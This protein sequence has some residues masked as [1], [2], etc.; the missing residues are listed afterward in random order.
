LVVEPNGEIR[1]NANATGG[2]GGTGSLGSQGGTGGTGSLGSQGGTGGTGSLGSQGGT[3]GTGSLGSQGGT[4]GTGSLGS[5]G[6]T[7][8]TGSRGSQGGTGGTG[9]LGSQGGTGGTGSLGSQGGTGGTGSLGSQGGTGGTGSLGS[10]GGTG[11]TG[12]LGSQGG[13]GGTGSLGSQGGTGGTGSLGSQG[14]TGGTGSLGSQGGT[15]GTGSRGSQGGTGGTGSLG[16]QGG[17]GGT[18]SLGSQGGTGGTG[19][20]GSQGGTGGTGSLGSQGSSASLSGT[21]GYISKFNSS[22]TLVNSIIYENANTIG[23]GA[24]GSTYKLDV[25]GT[26]RF[27]GDVRLD[28][29]ILLNYN[30]YKTASIYIKGVGGN[31]Q[32]GI[33]GS[34]AVVVNGNALSVGTSRG[35]TLTI[36]KKIDFSH[37]GSTTYDTYGLTG[38]S[39]NL[40]VALNNM[41]SAQIGILTSSDAFDASF[42]ANLRTVARKLGLSKLAQNGGSFRRPYAAIFMTSNT[43]DA[44]SSGT[45][46]TSGATGGARYCIEDFEFTSGNSSQAVIHVMAMTDGTGQ[47]AGFSGNQITTALYSTG[48]TTDPVVLVDSSGNVGI[49]NFSPRALLDLAKANNVGQVLLIGETAT[50]T[51]TGFGLDSST[52]GMRIFCPNIASE[53]IY[54]GGISTSDGSTWTRNHSFGIAGK[55]SWLNEQGGNAGIGTT[56]PAYKLDVNGTSGFRDTMAFGPSIG[57]ISWGSMGGGTGFGIRGE[58]GRGLSLGANGTWDYLV[59]NTSGNISINTTSPFTTGGTAQLTLLNSSV[60]LSMGASNSDMSYIRRLSAGVFQW[61]TYN[62]A[63]TGEIHLEPYG[64]NVGIGTTTISAKLHINSTTSGATLV[65]ADGTNGT[66]FSVVDDLSD[67]LM[68]VNNSAGLPV[69]EVFADDR[70]VLGQYGSGDFVLKNNKVGIGQSNPL[71]TLDVSGNIRFTGIPVG[72]STNCLV[73]EPNGE[74][75]RNANATGG[76]GG[77]GSLGSQ[78]GTGGTGSLGSQGGTGGT[79]SRGSQGGTGGTGSL[80]SQGGTG[81]TGS[82][83]SQGGT[84]GTGSL[85]SQGGTGGTGSRGSQGGTGGTGSLGSQGGTGGTGSLGSQGGTGGTG[86]LGSQGSQGAANASGTTNRIAKFTNTTTLGNSLATDDGTSQITLNGGAGAAYYI[87]NRTS[88]SYQGG[89]QWA[90]GGTP[91]WYNYMQSGETGDVLKWFAG[92]SDKLF[93]A[94]GANILGVGVSPSYTLDVNGNA[95]ATSFPTSSD[96]RFKKNIKPIEN[97]LQKIM[98]LRGVT[99]EWN[100][101]INNI[102]DGYTLNTP[103]IGFI[104]QEIEQV[105][106]ELVNTWKLSD[107]CPDARSLDYPRITAV[108]TEAIKEQ[109]AQINEL[110]SRVS[111]LERR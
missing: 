105:L 42:T 18:G 78:G 62:S 93:L 19:S 51:R 89:Y 98:K 104:A 29:G 64:G 101:F 65:R 12:S 23:I 111:A 99:Y 4:G 58:S 97:A 50:N 35:L 95:H 6:G 39:D 94:N 41:T 77:T 66:L 13:T 107:D 25:N 85:G 43:A 40:A 83:G 63:N 44:G 108:L 54:M 11:G 20:L 32:S 15:G 76:T 37:V 46:G 3:G 24:T 100:E 75:R 56:S 21:S 22:S 36:L 10:Q 33:G 92:S 53:A 109:Q 110:K 103:V 52:A 59:I 47:G 45:S 5:Q 87:V 8:G 26:A 71:Y 84:G 34:R 48:D 49:G 102:R 17:T 30:G 91:K 96:L 55:N 1:R 7:G 86:S 9:S 82:L 60:A 74:I 27:S 69:M 14:G 72:T 68:S 106:P 90:T 61:Q 16:S 31:F 81:G 88:T 28:S 70:V 38:D 2:T 80:G 57:L 67:S 79:G 73:V